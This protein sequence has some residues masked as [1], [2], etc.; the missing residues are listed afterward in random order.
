[1]TEQQYF[2]EQQIK[3]LRDAAHEQDK[4]LGRQLRDDAFVAFQYD[5]GFRIGESLEVRQ[6]WLSDDLSEVHLPSWAQKQYP[7]G[8]S[9][10]AVTLELDKSDIGVI[11]TLR[12]YLNSNW[13]KQQDTEYL[14]PT[15]Q[16]DQMTAQTA[17]NVIRRLAKEVD[18]QAHTT[19]GSR[20][21]PDELKTHAFRHSVGNWMLAEGYTMT[22]L[23]NRLRHSRLSTTEQTYEH[24]QRR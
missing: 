24:F 9:P 6:H 23:R 8:D 3:K 21:K 10:P 20:A 22:Q 13:Y 15:R 12:N 17:R 19:D 5:T 14:F 1:M 7:N 11:R 2:R 4:V 16:S 18:V